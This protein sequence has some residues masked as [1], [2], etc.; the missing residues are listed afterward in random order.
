M[1]LLETKQVS[2]SYGGVHAL[3]DVSVGIGESEIVVLM[4]PNGAGKSTVI[5]SMFGLA[6]RESGEIIMQD[7]IITPIPHAMVERGV[8]YVP[9]GRRV[10]TQLS[11]EENLE[12]GAYTVSSK[13]IIQERIAHAYEM[14]PILKKKRKALSGSLS[15]GQQQMLAVA[16]GLM[17]DPKILLLDEPTLGLAPVIVKELFE[18]IANINKERGTSLLIVEHNIQTLL[19]MADRAYVLAH[20]KVVAEDTAKRIHGSS[21]LEEVFM[22]TFDAS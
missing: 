8:S 3:Q 1:Y 16:R 11:V 6:P 14:F 18:L 15:G 13:E 4:G 7:E 2:V 12:I 22:G 9:Q 20:G 21:I 10:F 5:K 17:T 19:P